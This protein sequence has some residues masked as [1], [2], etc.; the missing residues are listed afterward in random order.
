M[1]VQ[2]TNRSGRLTCIPLNCGE[3][4]H[5]APGERSRAIEEFDLQGNAKV[6]KLLK[7]G[8]IAASEPAESGGAGKHARKK[9]GA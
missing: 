2:I 9:K 8:L 1:S 6:R 7:T 5:L 4:I 3:S